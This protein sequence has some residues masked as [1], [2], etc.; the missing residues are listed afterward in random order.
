MGTA[1][2]VIQQ[3]YAAFGRRDIPALL[4]LVASEVDWEFVGSGNTPYGGRRRNREEVA[5]FF[6]Q[7]AQTDAIHEFEPR[8]FIE[9]GEHVTVLG[10]VKGTVQQSKVDFSSEWAHVFTVKHGQVTRWRGFSDTAARLG[11]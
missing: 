7:L 8:E 2:N 9:A 4:E 11:K 3:A 6:S 10:W 5:A 1:L